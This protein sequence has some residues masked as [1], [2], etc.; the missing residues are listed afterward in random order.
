MTKTSSVPYEVTAMVE[1]G[2]WVVRIADLDLRCRVTTLAEVRPAARSMLARALV[3][4]PGAVTMTISVT[5]FT[6]GR[7]I[8]HRW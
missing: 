2:W 3:V 1:N 5:R 6:D 7:L 8:R 4:R